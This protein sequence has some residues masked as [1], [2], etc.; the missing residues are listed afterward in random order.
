MRNRQ[1]QCQTRIATVPLVKFTPVR[2]YTEQSYKCKLSKIN[3]PPH[4]FD[5]S[6]MADTVT[7]DHVLGMLS[8]P[9]PEDAPPDV[10]EESTDEE[11]DAAR[12]DDSDDDDMIGSET[13]TDEG[14]G[15]K[16]APS[17]MPERSPSIQKDKRP[18]KDTDTD[19]FDPTAISIHSDDKGAVKIMSDDVLVFCGKKMAAREHLCGLSGQDKWATFK[20]TYLSQLSGSPGL[21]ENTRAPA[22]SGKKPAASPRKPEMTR[23]LTLSPKKTRV[24]TES[25]EPSV[26]SWTLERCIEFAKKQAENTTSSQVLLEASK[27]FGIPVD[28]FR[29][30]A[31]EIRALAEVHAKAKSG[32][33]SMTAE[34]FAAAAANYAK[35]AELMTSLKEHG[36]AAE[37][38]CGDDSFDLAGFAE[39]LC[40]ARSKE[41]EALLI[42][43]DAFQKRLE[44]ELRSALKP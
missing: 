11:Y 34:G 33:E 40:G 4:N 22:Q 10:E 25:S 24:K 41:D 39:S 28:T 26:S 30:N 42:E 32:P 37:Q 35:L 2:V 8:E 1:R 5:T 36:V 27:K 29:A 18:R 13:D 12:D 20:K 43:L 23:A 16:R 19:A 14:A 44:S 7:A 15:S 9:V 38:L 31:G 21:L 3:Y 17:E 6:H